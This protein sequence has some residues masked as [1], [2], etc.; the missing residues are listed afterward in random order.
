M[1]AD[2][3]E[4][5]KGPGWDLY[6]PGKRWLPPLPWKRGERVRGLEASPFGKCSFTGIQRTSGLSDQTLQNRTSFTFRLAKQR[7]W[8]PPPLGPSGK[9]VPLTEPP[10]F[11]GEAVGSPRAPEHG[12]M[13]GRFS[14]QDNATRP[15]GHQSP[16]TEP[17]VSTFWTSSNIPQG[18]H[19]NCLFLWPLGLKFID[20]ATV[21]I[22]ELAL[23]LASFN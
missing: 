6:Q 18:F 5:G 2:H 15:L 8:V 3:W 11:T 12:E 4:G 23:E 9:L 14:P 1:A 10:G 7:F 20:Q 19:D 16:L 13:G 22:K 21:D 17:L